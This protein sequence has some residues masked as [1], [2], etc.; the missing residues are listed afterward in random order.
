MEE[1]GIKLPDDIITYDL[2][3]RLPS[4]L[5]NI[6]QNITHSKNREDIK[7]GTLL[8]HLKIHLNEL[9]VSSKS[10]GNSSTTTMFTKEDQC[11]KPGSN[12]KPGEH[13]PFSKL[14]T[15]AWCWMIHS[16]LQKN[17]K[18]TQDDSVSSFS[19]FSLHQPSTFVLD[20]GS[21]SHNNLPVI[22]LDAHGHHSHI[23]SSKMLQKSLGHVSYVWIC[24]K[25]RNSSQSSALV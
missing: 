24:K 21:T 23:T 22:K 17:F 3:R 18:K 1:V 11:C 7:P 25:I 16:E 2:L 10:N 9:K 8:D 4:S 20:S 14:H 5:D 6:K 15:K 13:N 12:R 19:A